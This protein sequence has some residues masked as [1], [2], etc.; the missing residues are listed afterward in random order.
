M[1]KKT[2][3]DAKSVAASLGGECTSE[4][5]SNSTDTLNWRCREGHEWV[6]P[7]ADISTAGKWCPMCCGRNGTH[8]TKAR[9][10]ARRRGGLCLSADYVDANTM[11]L[12][13]CKNGH[14]WESSFHYVVVGRQWCKTCSGL[15]VQRRKP[16]GYSLVSEQRAAI[17]AGARGE[18]ESLGD[19]PVKFWDENEDGCEN[20]LARS[21]DHAADAPRYH[22]TM[23]TGAYVCEIRNE[24]S[25]ELL[26]ASREAFAHA[27]FDA[28]SLFG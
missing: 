19:K 9:K 24:V 17:R 10:E 3:A 4:R 2:L 13:Q 27:E 6:A 8:I 22:P 25:D 1:R 26:W 28:S 5:Y 20:G 14:E 11:M 7:F 21:E 16:M 12:W 15:L 23:S 18:A